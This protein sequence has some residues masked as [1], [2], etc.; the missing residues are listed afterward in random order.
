MWDL[1][2]PGLKPV[3]PALAGGFLTTAPPGKPKLNM[4]LTLTSPHILPLPTFSYF[5]KFNALTIYLVCAKVKGTILVFEKLIQWRKETHRQLREE[6]Q[7]AP[8]STISINRNNWSLHMA[9]L[10]TLLEALNYLFPS[11]CYQVSP[12][13]GSVHL[14]HY[15]ELLYTFI[16]NCTWLIFLPCQNFS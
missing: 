2:R 8:L 6:K 9:S 3:S 16:Y 11:D 5:N 13:I 1:P 4:I 14:N 7:R 12:Q 10:I 15:S